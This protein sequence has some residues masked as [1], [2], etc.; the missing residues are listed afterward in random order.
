MIEIISVR[1][2][3]VISSLIFDGIA[4]PLDITQFRYALICP[5]NFS[6]NNKQE[7][8]EITLVNLPAEV[9]CMLDEDTIN[10]VIFIFLAIFK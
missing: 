6:E 3:Y 1:I 10:F 9:L 4:S 7:V 5:R 8:P 2:F